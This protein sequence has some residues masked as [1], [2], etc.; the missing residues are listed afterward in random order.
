MGNKNKSIINIPETRKVL[1]EKH[2]PYFTVEHFF[3]KEL[4]GCAILKTNTFPIENDVFY[5][6]NDKV[7][8]FY[9]LNNRYRDNQFYVRKNLWNKLNIEYNLSD[10]FISET[11]IGIF[12]KYISN[13]KNSVAVN[14]GSAQGFKADYFK[15]FIEKLV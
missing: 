5:I 13:L 12:K 11:I 15:R 14:G 8:F 2:N 6:K 1:F 9:C 3:V 7:L 10:K 4:N